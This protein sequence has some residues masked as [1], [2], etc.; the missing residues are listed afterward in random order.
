MKKLLILGCTMVIAFAM[1]SCNSES[2]EEAQSVPERAD[3]EEKYRW[4]L[5][6]IYETIEMWEK[7]FAYVEEHMADLKKYRGTLGESGETLL[8]CLQESEVMERKLDNMYVYAFMFKDQDTKNSEAHGRVDRIASIS[9]QFYQN[10]AFLWPEIQTIPEDKLMSFVDNTPGLEVYRH[11]FRDMIRQKKHILSEREEELLAMA[12]NVC[13]EFGSAREALTQADIKFPKVKNDVGDM[14]EL[15]YGRY[16]SLLKSKDPE[17]RRGAFEG[18]YGT[19]NKFKNT[20][21]ALYRGSV[22]K[23]IFN[24]RARHYNSCLEMALNGD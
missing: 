8:A 18:M 22:K 15:S 4:R 13:R 1:V 23:D 6:D 17:V 14:V 19:F 5:Q 11:P 10:R 3:I 21:A 7:D 2:G 16:Y 12:G 20:S 9:S 24:A